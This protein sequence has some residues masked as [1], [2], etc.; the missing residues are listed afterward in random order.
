M[1]R[2]KFFSSLLLIP[3]AIPT[4]ESTNE[5][6]DIQVKTD[7][8]LVLMQNIIQASTAANLDTI[9]NL[10]KLEKEIAV[11]HQKIKNDKYYS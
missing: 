6:Q 5:T 7:E 8:D 1:K 11:L 2:R 9:K 3:A 10:T 4:L